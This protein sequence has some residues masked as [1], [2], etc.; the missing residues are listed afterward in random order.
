MPIGNATWGDFTCNSEAE[1]VLQPD[2][3]IGSTCLRTDNAFARPGILFQCTGLPN[4]DPAN[5]AP[6]G[7]ITGDGNL[8]AG[9]SSVYAL[10]E[11]SAYVPLAASGIAF[12][13][14]CEF[15]GWY[16]TVA[17]GNITV[18]DGISAA[19]HLVVPTQALAV[20]PRPVMG[21]GTNGKLLLL[22]GCYVVLTGTPSVNVLVQTGA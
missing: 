19:G 13:G 22:D 8:V 7:V 18:Y 4:T 15:G 16:C 14:R 10:S 21:V 1:M 2:S 12:T 9:D 20:G 6:M 11:V 17:G 5:W 3:I